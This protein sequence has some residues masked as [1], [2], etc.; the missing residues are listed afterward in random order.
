MTPSAQGERRWLPPY[1][2]FLTRYNLP[3]PGA[4][5]LIRRRPEWLQ[6][7]TALF[8]HYT[9]PSMRAQT[10]ANLRWIV[11][12]DP[13]SPDW[14]LERMGQWEQAGLL[15]PVLRDRVSREDLLEDIRG[16]LGRDRGA[17]ITTNLDNDDGLAIAFAQRV[18]EAAVGTR[19]RAAVYL[20]TGLVAAGPR[21][22]LRRDRHNAFCS[23]REELSDPMTC[24]ADWHNRLSR[25]MPVVQVTGAPGWLQVVH[26][27]NVSNRARGRLVSPVEFAGSFAPGLLDGIPVPS[28]KERYRDAVVHAPFRAARDASRSVASRLAVEALGKSRFDAVKERLAHWRT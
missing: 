11:Y 1:H 21:L 17:L 25:H 22:Y 19:S 6:D 2:V 28:K 9:I 14:L 8:E 16:V 15:T 5:S 3:T 13:Q 27:T 10:A 26:G 4:E 18:Q 23:V 24:W 20:T 12:V 7:R